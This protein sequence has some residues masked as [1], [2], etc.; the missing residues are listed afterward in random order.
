[1]SEYMGER[2]VYLFSEDGRMYYLCTM[3][4]EFLF[5]VTMIDI[6]DK[7]KLNVSVC[8]RQKNEIFKTSV[9]MRDR[10][11]QNIIWDIL[12]E[13]LCSGLWYSHGKLE[14][15]TGTKIGA[16][17]FKQYY[18]EGND[19]LTEEGKTKAREIIKLLEQEQEVTYETIV[20]NFNEFFDIKIKIYT[21]IKK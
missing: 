14:Y 7:N 19:V 20:R 5:E 18:P 15:D 17:V 13:L 3:N 21:K 16:E 12:V 10:P 9:K 11:E 8:L 4:R 6:F 2:R 1:M